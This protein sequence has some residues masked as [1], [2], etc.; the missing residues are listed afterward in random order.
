MARPKQIASMYSEAGITGL[1]ELSISTRDSVTAGDYVQERF[2]LS[3][4]EGLRLM[5]NL[6]VTL[7]GMSQDRMR[8]A[9][10]GDC[11]RCGNYRMIHI[12][13]GSWKQPELVN[14][15]DCHDRYKAARPAYPVPSDG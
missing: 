10:A 1:V 12:D 14:C 15:P 3:F 13:N 5:Q 11:E 2:Q 8:N 6:M 7:A 4:E 9:V